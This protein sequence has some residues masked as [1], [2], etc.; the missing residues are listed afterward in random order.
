[1]TNHF[2]T[3]GYQVFA[4]ADSDFREMAAESFRT[5]VRLVD[6]NEES[7]R[8]WEHQSGKV[9]HLVNVHRRF[10]EFKA[11]I[12]SAPLQRAIK[13]IYGERPVFVTHSKISYKC[14]GINQIWLP[15]QD[16]GYKFSD[17]ISA[18]TA[19]GVFLEDCDDTNGTLQLFPGSHRLGLLPHRIVFAPE[20]TEPQVQI[21]VP[22]PMEPVDVGGQAGDIVAINGLTVH[23]SGANRRGGYRCLFLFEVEPYAGIAY[24]DDGSPPIILNASTGQVMSPRRP[25][26]Q[27]AK[28]LL[29]EN[30]LR[31]IL[32]IG[33]RLSNRILGW[34]PTVGPEPDS[35]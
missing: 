20:E 27:T 15:H 30:I 22:L 8:K 13:A 3:H 34:P 23:Q 9:K 6:E 18:E 31:P 10:S 32:M 29:R 1:M 12:T 35:G 17:K 14:Q 24:E 11:L 2:D 16:L 25:I 21:T 33:F 5:A 7:Q 28:H 19:F 4:D 26:L